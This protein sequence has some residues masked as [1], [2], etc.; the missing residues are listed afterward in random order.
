MILLMIVKLIRTCQY[1]AMICI[2]CCFFVV[3][4]L[5]GVCDREKLNG[6]VEMYFT[7]V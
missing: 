1:D 5:C 6:F 7:S 2:F 4:V 3:C